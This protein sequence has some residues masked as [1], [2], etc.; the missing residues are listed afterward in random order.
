MLR[1]LG[2]VVI[3][4]AILGAA[5][6]QAAPQI[7]GLVATA[8]PIPMQCRNGACTALLSAFCLQ[9]RRLAPEFGTV[10]EPA[11]DGSVTLAV[12]DSLGNAVRLD[13]AGLVE[14]RSHYGYTAMW[15]R[16]SLPLPG[17]LEPAAVAIEV[18]PRV[19]M[20]PRRIA[21]DP[22]ALTAAEI[23]VATGS[24]RLAAEA[25]FEGDADTARAARLTARLI[26]ALPVS[27]DVPAGIRDDIWSRVA[28]SGTPLAA[29]N[30]FLACGR[31]V[32]QSVGY[33]LRRCL[34]ERHERMQVRNTREYWE[35]LGGS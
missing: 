23:A 3:G 30:A 35:S 13:A 17:G 8:E 33:P 5:Q 24:L 18:G 12:V 32:D 21:G 29:R 11:Q 7:L 26:N 2:S 15:A 25:V 31:T 27:G 4:L 1:T 10:Y 19:S 16:L 20:L 22:D 34:E 14:F 6:A 28:T 9:E